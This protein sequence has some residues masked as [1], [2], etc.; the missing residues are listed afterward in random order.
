MYDDSCIAKRYYDNVCFI[1]THIPPTKRAKTYYI[2][3]YRKIT[4]PRA[5]AAECF[6]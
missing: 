4:H 6:V 3:I 1:L 2:R 5:R